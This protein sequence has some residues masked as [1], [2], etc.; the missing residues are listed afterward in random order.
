MSYE[1]YDGMALAD[2]GQAMVAL[3]EELDH[4]KEL[5]T[6][7]QKEYD[8]VC[9]HRIPPLMESIGITS[10][11]MDNGKGIR[12]QNEMY[13]AVNSELFD[14]FKSWLIEEGEAGIIKETIH[15]STLKAFI[16][17]RIKDGK[18]Y[19]PEIVQVT[20]QPKARFY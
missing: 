10:F 15:P 18:E 16:N 8:H 6:E 2:L 20:V 17:G 3:R 13:V 1:R 19:P 7:L 14:K 12:V 11:K 5:A 9:I 4:A